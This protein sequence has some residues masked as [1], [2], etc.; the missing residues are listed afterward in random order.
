MG[1]VGNGWW[2][3]AGNPQAMLLLHIQ[4]RL[5]IRKAGGDFKLAGKGTASAI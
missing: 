2:K 5:K 4:D 1:W 3:R